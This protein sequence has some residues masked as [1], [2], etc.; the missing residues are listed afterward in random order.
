GTI[1]LHE[2]NNTIGILIL[3]NFTGSVTGSGTMLLGAASTDTTIIHPNYDDNKRG[4][5]LNSGGTF[6]GD[7]S[8]TGPLD[9]FGDSS[10]GV[11][12]QGLLTGNVNLT[13]LGIH[14]DNSVGLRIAGAVSG[15]VAVNNLTMQGINSS[16]ILVL[17]PVGGT[18]TYTGGMTITGY[19][20][21]IPSTAT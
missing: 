6:H 18:L 7:I 17:A 16:G 12:L 3:P 14:G 5:I 13:N 9:I 21:V 1:T 11:D 4:I 8:Y 20:I 15:N 2:A 19:D 10:V